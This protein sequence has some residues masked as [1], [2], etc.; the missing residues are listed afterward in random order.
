MEAFGK[1]RQQG[2]SMS[3][4][5]FS[6]LCDRINPLCWYSADLQ[7]PDSPYNNPS[8]MKPTH[9]SDRLL[10]TTAVISFKQCNRRTS[11]VSPTIDALVATVNIL[12]VRFSEAA[13]QSTA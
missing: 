11:A 5:S 1:L 12:S 7:K 2:I 10:S 4:S 8:I 3:H 9:G 13:C 6:K